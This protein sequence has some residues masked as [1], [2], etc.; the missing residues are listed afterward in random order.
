[1]LLVVGLIVG[2]GAVVASA[3]TAVPTPVAFIYFALWLLALSW[4]IFAAAFDPRRL[5]WRLVMI[6]TPAI[7]AVLGLVVAGAMGADGVAVGFSIVPVVFLCMTCLLASG[8]TAIVDA[9]NN[10]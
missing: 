3:T 2:H 8:L 4:W 6:W 9:A 7:A 10:P 5:V 1:L